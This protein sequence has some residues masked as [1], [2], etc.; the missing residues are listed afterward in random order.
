MSTRKIVGFNDDIEFEV[1]NDQI[2]V[3][4]NGLLYKN[5]LKN[6]LFLDTL[7]AMDVQYE[8]VICEELVENVKESKCVKLNYDT[9]ELLDERKT[10]YTN[11]M[12][13]ND[14]QKNTKRQQNK[15]KINEKEKKRRNKRKMLKVG[16]DYKIK[17]YC[18]NDNPVF[19]KIVIPTNHFGKTE[20]DKYAPLCTDCFVFA[21]LSKRYYMLYKCS[22]TDRYCQHIKCW[23]CKDGSNGVCGGY[24]FC[25]MK[26]Y[27]I[28]RQSTKLRKYGKSC[29]CG[30][31]YGYDYGKKYK[32]CNYFRFDFNRTI[33]YNHYSGRNGNMIIEIQCENINFEPIEL[34]EYYSI[35]DS[36]D[37]D[38]NS[39]Y[40]D[41]DFDYFDYFD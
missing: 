36:D 7:C 12:Q 21:M 32:C 8:D 34:Y 3:I 41:T 30:E 6:G 10:Q 31:E 23:M 27:D 28:M 16:N 24:C 22:Y 29:S 40:N 39:Y 26:C 18:D 19:S 37:S 2:R 11:K 15:K 5:K 17:Q 4:D 20:I 25:G 38:D 13:K 35:Y 33:K 14:R 1:I 9:T